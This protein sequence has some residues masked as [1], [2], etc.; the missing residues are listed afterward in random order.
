MEQRGRITSLA[1]LA[2][3]DA[4]QDT[5]GLQG[6]ESTLLAQVQI[7]THQY[8]QVLLGWAVLNPFIPQTVLIVMI[9]PTQMQDLA[10]GLVEPCEFHTD[11]LLEL[12]QV[13]LDGI[14]SFWC[15]SCTTPL[16]VSCKLAEGA[17]NL[18]KSLMQMLNSTGPGM[19]P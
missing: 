13:P 10:L 2:T 8:P 1:L 19:D 3:L 17:L 7:F 9:A 11:P 4:T 12:V 16:D 18:A 6:C 5:V 15:D 14:P